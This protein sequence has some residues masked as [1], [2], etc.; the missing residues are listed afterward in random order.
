MAGFNEQI[1]S[2]RRKGSLH[3]DVGCEEGSGI[4]GHC[5]LIASNEDDCHKG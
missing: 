1:D 4:K 3:R 5:L 2:Q